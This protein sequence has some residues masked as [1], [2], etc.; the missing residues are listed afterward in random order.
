[1]T[2]GDSPHPWLAW[3]QTRTWRV[4][5]ALWVAGGVAF[6]AWFALSFSARGVDEDMLRSGDG[7]RVVETDTAISFIH[8]EDQTR[9]AL[10]FLPG[11]L[12]DPHAYAP[13]LRAVAREGHTAV[14]IKL[15]SLGGRHAMGAD[16]RRRAVNRALHVLRQEPGDRPWVVAGHSLGGLLAATVARESA[17]RISGLALLGT[18]HPRDFSLA[19]A[20][21]PVVKVYGTRD[22]V[23][24]VDR[25]MANAGNL[26][27]S[28]RWVAIEGGNHSQ[29]AYYGFQLTDHRADISREEQ[30][31]QVVSALLALLRR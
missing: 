23:A 21:Y 29:F 1:M 16:G 26:P 18:T 5:R 17:H 7:V 22:G 13:L 20:R 14:L 28:T 31:R 19:D 4:V 15:P 6:M 9:P 10:L 30:H 27:S 25:M 3:R 2:G 12:V 24:P 8:S 11:G